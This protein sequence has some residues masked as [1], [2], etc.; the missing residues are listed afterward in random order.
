MTVHLTSAA[1]C[2]STSRHK[3]ADVL[4][5]VEARRPASKQSGAVWSQRPAIWPPISALRR[6]R[7]YSVGDATGALHQSTCRPVSHD[8]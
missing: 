4:D 3:Y 6:A 5:S 1:V 7:Q 2:S 8:V